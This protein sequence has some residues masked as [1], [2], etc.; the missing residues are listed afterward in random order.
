MMSEMDVTRVDP[1][2][3]L[4]D[5]ENVEADESG[6]MSLSEITGL[7]EIGSTGGSGSTTSNGER[8]HSK[9]DKVLVSV[10]YLILVKK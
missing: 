5:W 9:E 4:V 2:A 1:E 8:E 7:R 3:A 10:R 6:D